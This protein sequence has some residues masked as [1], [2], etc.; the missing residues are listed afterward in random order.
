V[1]SGTWSTDLPPVSPETQSPLPSTTTRRPY[2][3][4]DPNPP[5]PTPWTLPPAVAQPVVAEVF[6]YDG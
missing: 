6:T 2:E 1:A 5:T 3:I 4:P